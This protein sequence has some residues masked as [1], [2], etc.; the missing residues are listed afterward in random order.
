MAIPPFPSQDLAKLVLGYLAEE[1]LMTAYDEFLQASP[2]L[3]AMQN[4]YDRIFMTSLKN[5]LAE[6][7]AVKIY[8]ETCRP[9][10]LRKKL[11]QCSSLLEIVKFLIN[12]VDISKLEA[13]EK[14]NN[15]D[16]RQVSNISKNN[17]C[18]VCNSSKLASCICTNRQTNQNVAQ[19]NE[20]LHSVETTSLADLP[21]NQ[22]A[23]RRP[24]RFLEKTSTALCGSV[25]NNRVHSTNVSMEMLSYNKEQNSS[26]SFVKSSGD[27]CPIGS[28]NST[29]K[30]V[31]LLK[32]SKEKIQ[33][34][35]S[36]LDKVCQNNKVVDNI[37]NITIQGIG[38]N[39]ISGAGSFQD[40]A[41]GVTGCNSPNAPVI[42]FSASETT[43]MQIAA[44]KDTE[45]M[46]DAQAVDKCELFFKVEPKR[47]SQKRN[48]QVL[49]TLKPKPPKEQKIK[50]LSNVKVDSPFQ[51]NERIHKMP[52]NNATSTPVQMQTIVING[53]PAYRTHPTRA[54]LQSFTKDEILAM[55]TII[56]VPVSNQSQISSCSQTTTT[57][58]QK[59][60]TSNTIDPEE[61]CLGP[62]IIDVP[63]SPIIKGN[64]TNVIE[65]SKIS[66]LVK[67]VDIMNNQIKNPS[68]PKDSHLTNVVD[69]NTPQVLPVA[70]KSSSTPRRTSHI[71]VLD[72]ATPRRD[73]QETINEKMIHH[74]A[75]THVEVFISRQS[76]EIGFDNNSVT[77]TEEI[78][79][80]PRTENNSIE[81]GATI[82]NDFTSG[83]VSYQKP[84]NKIS[85]WDADLRAMAAVNENQV[86]Q[87]STSKKTKKKKP[88]KKKIKDDDV[89]EINTVKPKSKKYRK[90]EASTVV[91][92]KEVAKVQDFPSIKPTINI[93]SGNDWNAVSLKGVSKKE[94]EKNSKPN[95]EKCTETPEGD[96]L[97]LQNVVDAKLNISELLET[98]YKQA[99]Y[100]IQMETPRCL[101]LDLPGEPMSD[102]KIMNIPT[103]RFFDSPKI[104]HLTPSS[105]SSR[106]TDYSSGGSYYKP[107]DQD[108]LRISDLEGPIISSK[109]EPC[110]EISNEGCDDSAKPSRPV[111][112]CA[113]NVSYYRNSRLKETENKS[114]LISPKNDTITAKSISDDKKEEYIK[115]ENKPKEAQCKSEL[116]K[117][118]SKKRKSP[119]IKDRSF[120]KIKPS[121]RTPSKENL[122]RTKKSVFLSKSPKFQKKF[123]ERNSNATPIIPSVPTKSRRKSST[124]RK[125]HCSKTFNSESSEQDSPKDVK[126]TKNIICGTNSTNV[127]DSDTEQL[128]LRWSDDGSQDIKSVQELSTTNEIE[129][130]SKIQEYLETTNKQYEVQV[131]TLQIDLIK[132]G[133]DAET[134]KIIERDLL[135]TPPRNDGNTA[136]LE[137]SSNSQNG[138][139]TFMQKTLK[140][141]DSNSTIEPKT[142]KSLDESEYEVE[143]SVSECNE[144]SKNFF[145]CEYVGQ[146]EK[147]NSS[148]VTLKDSFTMEICVDDDLT[149]RLRA[150]P[151][152]VLFD[153]D[154]SEEQEMYN[155]KETE[156]AVNS[157]VNIDKLYTPL[158]D[159]AKAQCYEIFN[160]TLTSLDTPLKVSSPKTGHEVTV[161]EVVIERDRTDSKDKT[162]TKKRKRPQSNSIDEPIET[163]KTKPDPQYLL[164]SANIQNMDIDSVLEKLH[165]P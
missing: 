119:M 48:S 64:K 26:N 157:I 57:T 9:F 109:D 10:T 129:D 115:P 93:K 45:N 156:D 66:G 92:D 12:F 155:A 123:K 54:N 44:N 8:V 114:N 70:K 4:E 97:T 73:L 20:N 152:T 99:F 141:D 159:T 94:N 39:F 153:Q 46:K 161:S 68:V 118:N 77:T 147:S 60:M 98:P 86:L 106:P 144:E 142:C 40:F 140:P 76:T 37:S 145:A 104:V 82:I 52:Q 105:Y 31:D 85:D 137:T 138:D 100:D 158:K 90:K 91:I 146:I 132:R 32:E 59:E 51:N 131:G 49:T 30:E 135:D 108:Y 11:F 134:A 80:M 163:K 126:G 63:N 151:F 50:I 116:K 43:K 71:R 21:G 1:Q 15:V 111:R 67:T 117:R 112:K 102:V 87:N 42:E 22:V 150:T 133:F 136:E 113:K 96:R 127:Q 19:N 36:I 2:Y 164:S 41:S 74:N 28:I 149:I 128:A 18:A 16:K 38:N 139:K 165:G 120:M 125:L 56:V 130:L 14:S 122:R 25:Q 58:S 13:I 72:F 33:E 78:N 29:A 124:P 69:T 17:E 81:K 47:N 55:P 148:P 143:L 27:N 65:T 35:D 75:N 34:F 5:I 62:L 121:A 89:V 53:K 95:D 160:S 24:V 7:R 23:R 79:G 103:P 162:E 154:P 83:N 88:E 84:K 107:D 101:G 6:Y 3:D 61:R 110:K